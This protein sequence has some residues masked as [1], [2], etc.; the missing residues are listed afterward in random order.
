MATGSPVRRASELM[1]MIGSPPRRS[2]GRRSPPAAF[3]GW[4]T[5]FVR[6]AAR[7]A[8]ARELESQTTNDA[9]SALS[10][11]RP[12]STMVI[13]MIA[14]GSVFFHERSDKC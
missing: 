9:F 7:R 14:G 8:S 6:A 3:A 12:S 1:L 4:L 11:K 5:L 2:A 10:C 13:S